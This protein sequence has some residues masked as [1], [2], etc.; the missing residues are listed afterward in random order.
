MVRHFASLCFTV[1]AFGLLVG[2]LPDERFSAFNTANPIPNSD[3]I[4]EPQLEVGTSPVPVSTLPVFGAPDQGQNGLVGVIYDL[5]DYPLDNPDWAGTRRAETSLAYFD[6]E[7]RTPL[8][9]PIVMSHL[10]IAERVFNTGFPNR[11]ELI[12]WFAIR[13]EG[14]IHIETSGSYSFGLVSDDGSRLFIDETILID[15]DGLQRSVDANGNEI[16]RTANRNLRAGWHRISVDYFQG[17]RYHIA[18]RLLWQTPGQSNFS[19][20]P[21]SALSRPE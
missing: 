6:L 12:E 10:D 13:F 11:P 3:P 14:R 20:I 21:A 4:D 15:N 7:S 18:L 1:V 8:E 16:R 17:P 9:T 19:A 5:S 2:C